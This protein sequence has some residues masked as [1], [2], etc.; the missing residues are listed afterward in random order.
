MNYLT[1]LALAT[2]AAAAAAQKHA[3]PSLWLAGDSTT[4]LHDTS[5]GVQGWGVVIGQYLQGITMQNLA[6]SGTSARTYA[7][8]GYFYN[9]V[10]QVVKGDYVVIEFGHNDGGVDAELAEYPRADLSGE[11]LTDSQTVTLANGTVEVVYTYTYYVEG[12]VDQV[13]AKGATPIISSTTPDNPY[14]SSTIT[15]NA[16]LATQFVK[17]AADA[18]AAKGVPYVD[19]FN[20]VMSLYAKLGPTVV[21]SY[22][23]ND[24]T[25]TNIAGATKVAWTFIN[26][27]K[28]AAADGVLATYVKSTW[29]GAG[30]RCSHP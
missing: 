7:R 8:E 4:A 11:S 19:H 17:Y 14:N 12:M 26:G 30:A 27:L 20:A 10:Q 29:E 16:E 28:C 2:S 25:H 21:N 6:V 1:L 15:I 5:E 13:L 22:Y 9:L 23:P 18:A 24:H 3:T